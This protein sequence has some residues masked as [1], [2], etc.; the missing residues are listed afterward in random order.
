MQGVKLG[1]HKLATASA[2]SV[3]D[4]FGFPRVSKKDYCEG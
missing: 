2:S 4:L 3:C 1:L